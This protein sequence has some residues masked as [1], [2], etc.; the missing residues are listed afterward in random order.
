MPAPGSRVTAESGGSASRGVGF[1]AGGEGSGSRG[2]EGS[3]NHTTEPLLRSVF[4]EQTDFTPGVLGSR[5]ILVISRKA[6]LPEPIGLPRPYIPIGT[7]GSPH[8]PLSDSGLD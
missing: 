8:H 1:A 7:P 5:K 6:D 2:S 4:P 3:G